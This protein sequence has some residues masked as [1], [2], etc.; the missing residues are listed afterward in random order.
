MY[1]EEAR[2]ARDPQYA[3]SKKRDCCTVETVA[4]A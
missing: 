2:G 1:E 4:T 3:G